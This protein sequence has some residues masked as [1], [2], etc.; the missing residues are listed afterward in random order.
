MKIK[1]TLGALADSLAALS[2]IAD[3][4]LAGRTAYRVAK[5]ARAVEAE[6]GPYDKA[7]RAI[8]GRYADEKTGE[9]ADARNRSKAAEEITELREQ[10]VE[11]EIQ[12]IHIDDLAD[13]R[14]KPIHLMQV[15]WMLVDDDKPEP[16][17][18][19]KNGRKKEAADA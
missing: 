6:T 11:I 14:V 17:A 2:E 1:T 7:R 13:L 3:M 18:K 10:E 12:A 19:R 5:T 15:E 16:V 9:I 8:I 4:P